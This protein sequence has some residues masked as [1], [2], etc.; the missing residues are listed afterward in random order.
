M[1][2]GDRIPAEMASRWWSLTG[3]A[4]FVG[5]GGMTE[6]AIHSTVFVLQ[7][8]DTRWSAVP[9]GQ[10]LANMHCR[11]VD[12]RGRDCPAWVGGELW[13]SGP[14]LAL[15]YLKDPVR[16]AEKFVEDA[17]RRWYRSGD[18][19]RY[20]PEGIIEYIGRTDQQIKIRGHRIELGEIETA[21]L[22]HP[23][24]LQASVGIVSPAARQLCASL[25][26][27]QPLSHAT[28]RS[29]L[30]AQLP[31]YAV[32]EHYQFLAEMPLTANG[33][34][35]RRALQQQAERQLASAERQF[36]PPEGEIEQRVAAL[37]QQLLQ[38]AQV[39]REDNFFVLGGDSLIATRLIAR[40]HEQSLTAPW[41]NSSPRQRWRHFVAM[42]DASIRCLTSRLAPMKPIVINRS[43]SA[44]SSAP[45]GSVAPG[46]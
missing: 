11:I 16:S 26:T 40:M 10:P 36:L 30:Q 13:V 44:I 27:L 4:A 3:Q 9:F 19:V 22:S 8:D 20:W 34:L 17:G 6:A 41:P 24:V 12:D 21:L 38:V 43:R 15:G 31:A 29:W 32:P 37:W 7:P 39:G 35:D 14:G 18:R 33:K 46:K 23:Q 5:L 2:G 45:S 1:M 25:V 28:L 42:S